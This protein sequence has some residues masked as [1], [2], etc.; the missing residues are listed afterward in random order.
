[1]STFLDSLPGDLTENHAMFDFVRTNYTNQFYG[2]L[3]SSSLSYRQF[4]QGFFISGNNEKG[5]PP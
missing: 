1:M 4:G 5:I 3:F 2:G